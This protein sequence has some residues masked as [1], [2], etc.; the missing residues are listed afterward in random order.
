ME[1]TGID[2]DCIRV[3]HYN[4]IKTRRSMFLGSV[5][6]RWRYVPHL[7]L[8]EFVAGLLIPRCLIAGI[9]CILMYSMVIRSEGIAYDIAI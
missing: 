7:S 1:F 8:M 2:I 3:Y 4:I 9:I 6:R 5:T